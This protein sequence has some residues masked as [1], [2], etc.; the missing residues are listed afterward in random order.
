M[1]SSKCCHV[2]SPSPLRFL[3]ALMPPWAH[4]EWER[5]TGTMEKRSTCP[6]ASA[7]LITAARPASPPP[8][9]TILGFVAA[10]FSLSSFSRRP[11]RAR[12]FPDTLLI[13]RCADAGLGLRR[14]QIGGRVLPLRHAERAQRE[15]AHHDQQYRQRGADASHLFAGP[16][17]D[18]DAPLGAE[19][20]DAVGEM[21]GGGDDADDI[22]DARPGALQFSLYFVKCRLR[23]R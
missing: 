9:T 8:T 22:E 20:I 14:I 13:D 7:I 1:V 18:R 16:L 5:F 19:Q 3:A 23:M 11:Q 10:M 12:I 21:P 2:V 15:H 17:A 4:T 6:P